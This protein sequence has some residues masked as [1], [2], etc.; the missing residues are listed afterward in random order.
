MAY[1]IPEPCKFPSLDSCQE[2]IRP[3][4]KLNLAPHPVV[5]LVLQVGDAEKFPRALCFESLA[6]FSF[7]PPPPLFRFGNQGPCFIAIEEN[8]GDTETYRA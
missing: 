3:T 4:R 5:G 6:L 1:G 2:R 8:G 7:F